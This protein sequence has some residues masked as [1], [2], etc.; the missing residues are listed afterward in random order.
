MVLMK[1]EKV[2]EP[3]KPVADKGKRNPDCDLYSDCLDIA[4]KEDWPTFNCESCPY[5][6]TDPV[7]KKAIS[8][9]KRLCE[10]CGKKPTISPK[11]TLC[12]SCMAVRSHKDKKAKRKGP[13]EPNKKSVIHDKPKAE[14][15]TPRADLE[16]IISFEKYET[17][18]K[19]VK[20]LAEK[21]M[22]PLDLQILYLLKNSL[23]G[24][25]N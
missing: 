16:L 19:E 3:G 2:M 23:K 20:D 4:A 21:E 22:R 11:H 14:K 7:G 5:Y 15:F 17:I 8:E 25:P 10:E 1:T 24:D 12:P 6:S 18:L 13:R 9:N